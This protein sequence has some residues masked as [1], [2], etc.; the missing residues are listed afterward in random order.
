MSLKVIKDAKLMKLKNLF[1]ASKYP[2][3]SKG[4]FSPTLDYLVII[5]TL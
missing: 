1:R 2:K 4:Q 3:L 5:K